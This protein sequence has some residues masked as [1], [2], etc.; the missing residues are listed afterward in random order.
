MKQYYCTLFLSI[1]VSMPIT[2]QEIEILADSAAIKT[3][4]FD[5]KVL[6]DLLLEAE[7]QFEADYAFR[8]SLFFSPYDFD[9]TYFSDSK[10]EIKFLP[11]KT[12]LFQTPDFSISGNGFISPQGGF[13]NLTMG[14][15]RF[16]WNINDKLSLYGSPSIGSFYDG[17][18]TPMTPNYFVNLRAGLSYQVNDWLTLQANGQY[19]Y[20]GYLPYNTPDF[21]PKRSVGGG[22]V[23]KIFDWF[24]MAVGVDYANING[25]WT[26]M[27]YLRPVFFFPEKKKK[28]KEIPEYWY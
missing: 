3:N 17:I 12:A 27:F 20:G 15:L 19:T 14:G 18:I 11:P 5:E 10:P 1:V 6:N 28:K 4:E 24:G 22:A 21:Y 26:P 13:D 16:N 25:T 8:R 7:P 23:L 9:P 2:A